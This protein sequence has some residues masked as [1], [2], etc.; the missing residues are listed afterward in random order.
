VATKRNLN[1]ESLPN[2]STGIDASLDKNKFAIT[3]SDTLYLRAP[4]NAL[5]V[6]GA[7]NVAFI[8]ER[9]ETVVMTFAAGGPY[10]IGSTSRIMSTS[11]TATSL[12][13]ITD[14]GLR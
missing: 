14:K 1:G 3:P 8:N 7:G 5:M 6:G 13:G 11:T 4:I 2:K 10:F 12:V 9:G